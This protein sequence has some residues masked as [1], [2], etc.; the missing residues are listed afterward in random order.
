MSDINCQ[1]RLGLSIMD[2]DDAL[3]S[4]IPIH[5][6]TTLEPNVQLHQFP[7]LTRPLQVPPSAAQA[8]KKISAR[9]K[10]KAGRIE[11]HVPVDVRPDVWNV[12]RGRELGEARADEDAEE[13]GIE[14][15]KS[16]HKDDQPELRLNEVRMRS[17]RVTEKSVYMLGIM[18]EGTS[19]LSRHPYNSVA[20]PM[21]ANYISTPFL[22]SINFVLRS[23]ISMSC[24]KN[25]IVEPQM[26]V[27]IRT[28]VHLQT[29]MIQ[30][31]HP[32]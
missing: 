5:L 21:K 27:P 19:I 23:P 12:E 11:V 8:G 1:L 31:R 24:P 28:M 20:H 3:L 10:P 22:K 4:V 6:S 14:R 32:S 17:E 26:V 30:T 13:R 2:P 25:P 7:L 15:K 18:R 9:Y 16:R 29:Q